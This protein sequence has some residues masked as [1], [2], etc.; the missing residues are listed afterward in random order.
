[1]LE[2]LGICGDWKMPLIKSR[3]F[4]GLNKVHMYD[5]ITWLVLLK[6]A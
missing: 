6:A 3:I 4:L 2:L 1:M 5:V